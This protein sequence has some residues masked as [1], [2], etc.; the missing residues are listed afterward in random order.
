MAN[1]KKVFRIVLKKDNTFVVKEKST[2]VR[3]KTSGRGP[4]GPIG[5]LG[6]QGPK[7]SAPWGLIEGNIND[8]VDLKQALD[9]KQSTIPLGTVNQYY[10]GDKT[11]QTLDKST[12]GLSNVNNT[13]DASKPISIATQSAIDLL[14]TKSDT[15]TKSQVDL[16]DETVEA[17]AREELNAHKNNH[18]NPHLTT[19]SQVGLGNVDNTSDAN[20]PVSTATQT[21]ISLLATKEDTYS[22]SQVDSKDSAVATTAQTNLTSHTSNTNNPHSTTKTQVGLGNVDNTSDANKPVS[23]A[24]QTALNAKYDS[25]NPAGYVTSAGAATAAPVKSVAGRTGIITLTKSD[26]GLGNVDN[27]TDANKPISSAVAIAL[28]NKADLIGGKIPESQLPAFV[29]DVMSYAN[30]A[31]FPATGD[32]G[33]IYIAKDTNLTYRWT[34]TVYTE[35]SPSI[36]LG[37]TSA[38]AYRG[39]RGKIAYEHTLLQ[40]NPHGVTKSQIDLGNVDNTSDANKPISTAQQSALDL[41]ANDTDVVKTTGNQSNISGTKQFNSLI[42]S[43][44]IAPRITATYALGTASLVYTNLFSSRVTLNSTAYIDGSSAGVLSVTG[45]LRVQDGSNALDVV[46]KGQLDLKANSTDLA[47]YV[48]KAGD[49]MTGNLTLSQGTPRI[50]FATTSGNTLSLRGNSNALYFAND[51]NGVYNA[52]LTSTGLALYSGGSVINPTHTLTLPSVATGI[53]AYN[54]T[55]QTTNYERYR[56]RWESN[57]FVIGHESGGTGVARGMK[58]GPFG[59]LEL[60]PSDATNAAYALFPRGATASGVSQVRITGGLF[61]SSGI[62]YSHDVRPTINQSGSAGYTALLINPNI[63]SEGTGLKTLID[64]QLTGVSKFRVDNAG[65]ITSAPLAGSGTTMVVSDNNGTIGMQPIPTYDLTPY[66]PK[67]AGVSNPFTGTLYTRSMQ[68]VQDLTSQI[69]TPFFYYTDLYA[70]RHFFNSTAYIDGSTAGGLDIY[71][72]PNF[73]SD[74]LFI[75]E[76]NTIK[77]GLVSQI[78]GQ[79]LSYG[80]NYGQLSSTPVSTNAGAFLRVDTRDTLADQLF[81]VTYVPAGTSSEQ[82]VLKVSRTGDIVH[83]GNINSTT[84][85]SGT[86]GLAS[87][88][89]AAVYSNRIYLNSALNIDGGTSGTATVNGNMSVSGSLNVATVNL[90]N[91]RRT[92]TTTTSNG[93]DSVNRIN[94]NNRGLFDNIGALAGQGD[95]LYNA[96]RNPDYTVTS[97]YGNANSLFDSDLSSNVL[98]PVA[99]LATAPWVLTVI[100]N[101]NIVTSDVGNLIFTGHRLGNN[102]V[103]LT[104]Y[105]IETYNSDGSWSVIVDRTGVN[106]L[107]DVISYPLHVV[108]GTYPD[109]TSNYHNVHGI[110]LTV[111]GA[112]SSNFSTGN[113]AISSMQIRD[114]RPSM[115]P[116]RGLGALDLRG[117]T[118]YGD[119]TLTNKT[120]DVSFGLITSSSAFRFVNPLSSGVNYIQSGLTTSAGSAADLRIGP[121]ATTSNS[122][123]TFQGTTGFVG[124]GTQNPTN[125]VHIS[126][127][128]VVPLLI[129]RTSGF[130]AGIQY[131]NTVGSMHAGLS[132]S[133]HFAIGLSND[134]TTA[135]VTVQNDGK[136]AI[137][138]TI[139][140]THT[141]TL[142]SGATGFAS[143]NT[144]DQTV[145]YERL[146]QY[147]DN[148]TYRIQTE[149]AGT[150]TGRAVLIG[151]QATNITL[152][153]GTGTNNLGANYDFRRG[154]SFTSIGAVLASFFV[155]LSTATGINTVLDIGSN[156]SQ[157]GTA[158]YNMILINP[159]EITVGSGQKNLIDAQVSNVSKFRVDNNGN[160]TS[161][162]LAGAGARMVVAD[163][164]GLM[165]TQAIPSGG[166]GGGTGTVTSISSTSGDLTIANPTTTP[167]LTVISA[168]KFTT[169]RTINGVS[170]DGTANITIFDATK[171]PVVT[172]GTTSQY[173]RGDKSWQTL[174]K[175]AVGLG[176]VDNTSDLLKPIS[177]A[178][179]TELD[180]K[181]SLANGGQV[182]GS[183]GFAN[184]VEFQSNIQMGLSNI[185]NANNINGTNINGEYIN[186]N[187]LGSGYNFPMTVTSDLDFTSTEKIINL[188]NGTNAGDAVNKSQLDTKQATLVSGTN[189]KTINGESIVGSG[190]VVVTAPDNSIAMAIA[191]G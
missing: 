64:A 170:F 61:A 82:Q 85:N 62:Q 56:A 164:N 28:T 134:L 172:A 11:F 21:A 74:R 32:D 14:A 166:G 180:D 63:T 87:N 52:V 100:K 149:S 44:N 39:D 114:Y 43:S 67:A 174:D 138:S 123:M 120:S 176:N 65:N 104:D 29:D 156:V 33:K 179:Q 25:S 186:G 152:R 128:T 122:W 108:G 102:A 146:R 90:G 111:R 109:G 132:S 1:E 135:L 53:A 163:A 119:V 98:V 117:G 168:P 27:T 187:N 70:R 93:F 31:A 57:I 183:V 4:A 42:N 118:V 88:Y 24:T 95:Y 182:N 106:D 159:N 23:T 133:G 145:N 91:A 136:V 137:G 50:N 92:T 18:E 79:L 144:S 86:V 35:I 139:T 121:Y 191:L 151:T 48:L 101:G 161:L 127:N 107:V 126:T 103:A 157:T 8:Q 167:T 112:T 162:S 165:S 5:P 184:T 36:A 190:N 15:Y 16:K 30:Q 76:G 37:E 7:G 110:R 124:I 113:L 99:N 83:R 169:A 115:S 175:T 188:P 81:N 3:I 46:N 34:G 80:V 142:G 158:G 12:V 58:L 181:L 131:K 177:T 77:N 143:Y 26:V 73:M 17:A 147:W 20:K 45:A 68:A 173:Y 60:T 129:E 40:N 94:M 6:P 54:T 148:N 69:G 178:T 78:N 51:T 130:N 71:G 55:D 150:G 141:L 13:S 19:K 38:T 185:E 160:I 155:P 47:N 171:E 75:A 72:T 9:S 89:Y 49:T 105:T 22:K 189:I 154:S 140:A 66:M 41:K 116:A 84:A 96:D 153:H 59:A 97:N 2:L 125:P 10:R